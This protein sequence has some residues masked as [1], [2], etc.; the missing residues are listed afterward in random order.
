MSTTFEMLERERDLYRNK[1]N[2]LEEAYRMALADRDKLKE[3][4]DGLR[5]RPD[6]FPFRVTA[7]AWSV[8]IKMQPIVDKHTG[9]ISGWLRDDGTRIEADLVIRTAG[10]EGSLEF[11][12][13]E[14]RE[15]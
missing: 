11:R 14:R 5:D 7:E 3:E 8:L 1:V 15:T 4:L 10:T 6:R 13:A 2:R 12:K 9:I